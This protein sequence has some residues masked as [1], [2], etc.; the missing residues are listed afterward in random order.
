[1]DKGASGGGRPHFSP[2]KRLLFTCILLVL[3]FGGAELLCR[4]LG[5]GRRLEV[6][7][8]ISDWHQSPDG[9][10]FWVIRGNGYN[11]DG[12]CD[13]DH[14]VEKPPNTFR[15]VCLGDSVTAG[16]G[17]AMRESYPSVLQT[18]YDQLNLPVQMEVFNIAVSYWSTLQEVAGYRVIARKYQPDQVFV[19]FCLNDVAEMHNN[20][21]RPPPLA[22]RFLA[23]NSALVRWLV[24]AEGRQVHDVLELFKQPSSVAVQNGWQLVFDELLNLQA[25]TR[26]DGCELAVLI[27]PF[28]FQLEEGAQEPV[29]QRALFRFCF[30]HDIPCFDLL[31]VLKPMGP[32][33]MLD[34]SHLSPAGARA[35]AEAIV[36]WGISGCTACGYDLTDFGGDRCPRCQAP[37]RRENK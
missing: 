11:Q 9:R 4:L 34:E 26:S 24:D 16:H 2:A 17:V 18:Y 14:A 37:I 5:L 31:D 20:L 1:M 13:R 23:N 30:E 8:Y 15:V 3:V 22:A 21:Q 35:V 10:R 32:E 6:A 29:P 28:R 33:A 25:D 7:Q 36:R 19:G 12:M 27:F